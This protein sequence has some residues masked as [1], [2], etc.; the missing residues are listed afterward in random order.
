VQSAFYEPAGT[1]AFAASPATVGAW[2]AQAQHGG[3]PSALAARAIQRHEPD[4][5]QRLARVAVD[6]LRPVPVGKV[7]IRTRTVRHSLSQPGI[8]IGY[9]T[10]LY[11]ACA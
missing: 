6:I 3:P 10:M 2:S 7:T 11:P 1:G 9:S 8:A 4:E 5:G